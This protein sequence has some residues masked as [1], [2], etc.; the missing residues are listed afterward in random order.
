MQRSIAQNTKQRLSKS[1]V[2]SAA[3]YFL[4]PEESLH[5]R[6]LPCSLYDSIS[7][8]KEWCPKNKN[9]K[10]PMRSLVTRLPYLVIS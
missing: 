10:I 3:W 4:S 5:T 9:T 1:T 2:I 7:N 8:C 6:R